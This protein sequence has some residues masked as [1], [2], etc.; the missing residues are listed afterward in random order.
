MFCSISVKQNL[1]GAEVRGIFCMLKLAA[2]P[3]GFCYAQIKKNVSLV[4]QCRSGPSL[5]ANFFLHDIVQVLHLN[6]SD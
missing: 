2:V 6:V 4:M 3:F 1:L 5:S